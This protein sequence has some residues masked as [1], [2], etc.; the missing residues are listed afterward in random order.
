[1]S[2]R[3]EGPLP[4][5][6]GPKEVKNKPKINPNQPNSAQ[7]HHGPTLQDQRRH[8]DESGLKVAALLVGSVR[9]NLLQVVHTISL[10]SV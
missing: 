8:H 2:P 9:P 1:M 10:W 4:A 3:G 5:N 7:N 6:Q